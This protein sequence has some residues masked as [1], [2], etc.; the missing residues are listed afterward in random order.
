MVPVETV[1]ANQPKQ[2]S[3]KIMST[4][5]IKTT[6]T[7]SSK[8]NRSPETG[9]GET[10]NSPEA[11]PAE[12]LSPVPDAAQSDNP[13]ESSLTDVHVHLQDF[14][15]GTDLSLV[16]ERARKNRVYRVICSATTPADWSRV[17]Q[18]GAQFPDVLTSFGI[19]PWFVSKVSGTWQNYLA[20]LLDQPNMSGYYPA[21]GEIGL[22]FAMKERDNSIQESFFIEQLEIA[23]ER[24][25]PVIV[26]SVHAVERVLE[27]LKKHAGIPVCLLH[28]FVGSEQQ[29]NRAVDLGCFF[30][31]SIRS[32]RKSHKKE[33]QTILQ[34]PRDR[35]LLESDGPTLL[36]PREFFGSD[37]PGIL[38]QERGEDGFLLHEPAFIVQTFQEICKIK[39]M[40]DDEF[41]HQ[42][43]MNEN[44]FL[45][46]WKQA[47][48]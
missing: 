2:K 41:Y 13:K 16:L 35:I 8:P 30:S 38:I 28:G 12:N 6:S 23:Q 19:H 29:I 24:K 36:P 21:I 44:H 48:Q 37:S 17:Q 4:D 3:A 25:L 14:Q 27:L 46:F 43:Q 9:S 39:K 45:S 18:I 7:A 22:D 15:F 34:A 5:S 31:F 33:R 11:G 1:Q 10:A 40:D 47:K 20:I 32:V 42:I 26:H